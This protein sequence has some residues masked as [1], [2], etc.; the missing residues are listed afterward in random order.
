MKHL[1]LSTIAAVL[2]VGCGTSLYEAAEE[3]QIEEVKKLLA[4]GADVN[5]KTKF[6]ET[7][8]HFA[9]ENGQKEVAE[10]LIDKGANVN[11]HAKW[12]RTP[13]HSTAKTGQ[14]SIIELLITAGANVNAE[15]FE[16][17]TPLDEAIN[18]KHNETAA[19]LRKHGG[20]TGEELK[21]A[22]N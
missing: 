13:L 3:G 18:Y 8:L 12:E 7:P 11:A 9:A 6:K 15:D 10:L 17:K 5:A 21:A 1:L 19:L 2:V 22:G 20:K 16:N 4:A 14:K